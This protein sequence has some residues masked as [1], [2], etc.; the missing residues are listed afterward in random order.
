MFFVTVFALSC[1]EK[2]MKSKQTVKGA[3]F[4]VD[5]KTGGLLFGSSFFKENAKSFWKTWP[6]Q[7][8][9][10]C[11]NENVLVI[12]IRTINHNQQLVSGTSIFVRK[13]DKCWYRSITI[14]RKEIDSL[15]GIVTLIGLSDRVKVTYSRNYEVRD[16]KRLDLK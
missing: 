3:A 6:G 4:Q 1:A 12:E 13:E 9:F 5:T 8:V 7:C 16:Y 2:P 10:H 15:G 11:Q 14:P